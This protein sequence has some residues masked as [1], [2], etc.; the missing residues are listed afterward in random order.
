MSRRLTGGRAANPMKTVALTAM[1]L[2]RWNE[3]RPLG[4]NDEY[5]ND[6][7]FECKDCGYCFNK[8]DDWDDFC[9]EC[10]SKNVGGGGFYG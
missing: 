6:P 7:D 10:E 2:E 1:A 3:L 4:P 8:P 9:P 5:P